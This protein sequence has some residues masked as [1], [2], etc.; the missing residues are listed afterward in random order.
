[1]WI[2]LQQTLS[3]FLSIPTSALCS[4][5]YMWKKI[6][7]SQNWLPHKTIV[8]CRRSKRLPIEKIQVVDKKIKLYWLGV[9]TKNHKQTTLSA[10][11]NISKTRSPQISNNKNAIWNKKDVHTAIRHQQ[12][13]PHMITSCNAI[14]QDKEKIYVSKYYHNSYHHNIIPPFLEKTSSTMFQKTTP[15]SLKTIIT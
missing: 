12:T 5:Q 4:L 10:T 11:N 8:S 1:M 6:C 2:I 3:P 9:S 15:I 7:T 13:R 14:N